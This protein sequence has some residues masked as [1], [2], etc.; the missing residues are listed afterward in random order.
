MPEKT[1]IIRAMNLGQVYTKPSVAQYMVNLFT[2][3]AEARVLDPCFGQGAFVDALMT[4]GRY[5]VIGVELDP[6]SYAANTDKA[7][8][9]CKLYCGNFFVLDTAEK[10]D[11]I[12][13]NPP[14]VRQEEI[15]DM[16]ETY[17]V[18][19]ERLKSLIDVEID[20]KAN[21]YMYFL[22][23]AIKLLKNDGELI[24]IFPNSWENTKAGIKFK[25]ALTANCKIGKHITVT[26]NP[27]VGDPIVDVEILK[28]YKT[29]RSIDMLSIELNVDGDSVEERAIANTNDL[30]FGNAV[31][32]SWYAQ[33]RRGKS[34]GGNKIFINP[35]MF[36][37]Q[38]LTDILSSPK[39]VN[40]FT[41]KQAKTDRYL[42]IT[43]S[44]I[45][46]EPAVTEYLDEW[47]EIIK[48]EGEPKALYDQIEQSPEAWYV[49]N[50]IGAGTIVFPYI[51]RDSVRF[52]LNE[53]KLLARDNFYVITSAIDKRL[54]MAL[55][56][57]YFIWYQLE[58]CGK[59]YGNNV[60]KIQKY[61]VDDLQ[62]ISPEIISS[63][64]TA[65]LKDLAK[66]LIEKADLQIIRQ[67]TEVLAK[68]YENDNIENLLNDARNKRLKR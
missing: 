17:G 55:L 47:K 51:I 23:Y 28:L 61:D 35:A 8:D 68:Y 37:T 25:K 16:Q 14:Y 27:F 64:D 40:G 12:V 15:D 13:M 57:N 22:L 54:L 63:E 31:S 9:R 48:K 6:K 19:K 2:L 34:T 65:R 4:D 29:S 58:K 39:D 5:N 33:I 60:L 30:E 42:M 44:D 32:L 38:C 50:D 59:T 52:I 7:N 10:Y 53:R 66:D 21:L 62:I 24:V 43:S 45:Q 56:N 36:S 46:L 49:T 11:G 1:T 41:T 3:P 20:A 67:I 18:S 26:G